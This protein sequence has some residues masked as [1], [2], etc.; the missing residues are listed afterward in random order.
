MLSAS[1]M[2]DF[3]A[4]IV[5]AGFEVRDFRSVHV[6]DP[7]PTL[8]AHA[9]T[10]TVT[11]HRPARVIAIAYPTQAQNREC[12]GPGP[13]MPGNGS[14]DRRVVAEEPRRQ[15][16]R[17]FFNY[18]FQLEI[19]RTPPYGHCPLFPKAVVQSSPKTAN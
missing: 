5:K 13:G 6:D 17:N 3:E 14:A 16:S 9:V 1:E 4:T 8:E 11:V 2:E 15:K 7:T 12:F 10:G 19:A 18:F